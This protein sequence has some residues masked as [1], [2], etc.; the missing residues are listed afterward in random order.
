[1]DDKARQ[2]AIELV[3]RIAA[4]ATNEND[5]DAA[6]DELAKLVPDPNI[7]DLI[8]WPSQHPLSAGLDK[9]D[10]TPELIVEL[11]GRY[12]PIQQ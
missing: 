12:K 2:R 7:S 4:L 5:A 10:L 1:M 6:L 11:A 8:F 9:G 3:E